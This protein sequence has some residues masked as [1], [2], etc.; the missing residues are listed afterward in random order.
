M[1]F[2]F[3]I[4][5]KFIIFFNA[6]DFQTIC[7]FH[8]I[9]EE[10]RKILHDADVERMLVSL[11]SHEDEGVRAASAQ[12][13]AILSES[14]VCQDRIAELGEYMLEYEYYIMNR[15]IFFEIIKT[16]IYSNKNNL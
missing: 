10:T 2:I 13:I 7:P 4:L 3:V 11:L 16:F 8:F 6:F 5:K 12:V 1:L 15:I 14:S 9:L